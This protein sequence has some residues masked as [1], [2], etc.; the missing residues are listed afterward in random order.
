ME[1]EIVGGTN[2]AT[3]F[4]DPTK[5]PVLEN[6]KEE[7]TISGGADGAFNPDLKQPIVPPP[8]PKYVI[9]FPS[10]PL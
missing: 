6:F 7:P 10:D 2:D 9:P 8:P 4:E 5:A 3:N 1:L